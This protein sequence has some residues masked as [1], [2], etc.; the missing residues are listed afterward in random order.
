MSAPNLE[1]APCEVSAG[2]QQ[3]CN[4]LTN[5]IHI[6]PSETKCIALTVPPMCKRLPDAQDDRHRSHSEQG[7]E[8]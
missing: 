6:S 1:W 2:V 4:V 5:K 8:A 7:L 3:D